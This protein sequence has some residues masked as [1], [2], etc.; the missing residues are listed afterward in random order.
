[1]CY[2]YRYS[3]RIAIIQTWN[4]G[5]VA[6]RTKNRIHELRTG[7]SVNHNE[8][9]VA[10]YRWNLDY[11]DP[12]IFWNPA[13]NHHHWHSVGKTAFQTGFFGAYPVWQKSCVKMLNVD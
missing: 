11:A 10:F 5:I 4:P 13:R 2:H 8:H 3:F 12:C 1:M 7:L 9:F 6:I